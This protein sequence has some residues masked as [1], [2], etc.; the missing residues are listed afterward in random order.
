M[1]ATIKKNETK[2]EAR[3]FINFMFDIELNYEFNLDI[4]AKILP[5]IL[6]ETLKLKQ[7]I[8]QIY[9]N[10]DNMLSSKA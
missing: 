2:T 7:L 5:P 10:A 4:S 3:K 9:R 6:K 8:A 1:F